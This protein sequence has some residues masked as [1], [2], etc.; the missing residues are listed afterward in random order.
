M[1]TATPLS[2]DTAR[3]PGEPEAHRRLRA[4]LEQGLPLTPRPWQALAE[5]AGM[6]EEEVM[7]CVRRWQADGMIKRL[8]LVV[9]HRRLGIQAN[10]MVVWDVPDERVALVGRRLARETAVTL[11]YRRP[12]R[13]PDWPYNLFCMIHGARRERVLAELS[14]I[15]ERLGL[16]ELEHRVLFS[17]H[18]YRQCGGRY[19]REGAA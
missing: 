10:A 5:Q 13:L 18:A 4:L 2:H 15:V 17:T 11:C 7:A 6:A 9:R 14:A 1:S 3:A 19:V 16:G 12:R 8:G